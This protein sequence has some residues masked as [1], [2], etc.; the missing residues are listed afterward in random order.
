M[1]TTRGWRISGKERIPSNLRT[2]FVLEMHEVV[3]DSSRLDLEPEP[4]GGSF[5]LH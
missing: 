2:P 1:L 5:K 3:Q 4:H